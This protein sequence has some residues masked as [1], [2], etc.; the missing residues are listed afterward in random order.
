MKTTI[1]AD[2]TFKQYRFPSDTV[3]IT[4]FHS[5]A[6]RATM[7]AQMAKLLGEQDPAHVSVAHT[8]FVLVRDLDRGQLHVQTQVGTFSMP[9]HHA[10]SIVLDF[11]ECA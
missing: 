5:P 3:P 9:L 2:G 10:F 1:D 11:A 6:D 7:V 8:S 4:L